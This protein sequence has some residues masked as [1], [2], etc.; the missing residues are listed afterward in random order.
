MSTSAAPTSPVVLYGR[1]GCHL[2]DD[3]RAVVEAVCAE[4]GVAWT[5]VDV[6]APGVD[7][8]LREQYGEYLPVVTVGGV[9]QGFWRVDARRLARAVGRISAGRADLG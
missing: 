7:P 2:C 1:A 3:A 9:Q 4:A 5:E 8:V 6:D